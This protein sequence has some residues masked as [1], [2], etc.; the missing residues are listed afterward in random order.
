MNYNQT[1]E[2]KLN[3]KEDFNII[4]KILEEKKNLKLEK[5]E[6]EN[7]IKVESKKLSKFELKIKYHSNNTM[8]ISLKAENESLKTTKGLLTGIYLVIAPIFIIAMV[9]DKELY[10]IE[11]IVYPLIICGAYL[12]IPILAKIAMITN[13]IENKNEK[14]DKLINEIKTA[15]NKV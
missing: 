10:L 15:Y 5:N 1:T 7:Y 3:S 14:A 4:Y 6:T 9:L 13:F 11:K 2:L 8:K 12:F